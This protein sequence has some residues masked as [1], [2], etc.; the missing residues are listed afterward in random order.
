MEVRQY[1]ADSASLV[2]TLCQ[3]FGRLCRGLAGLNPRF[4]IVLFAKTSPGKFYIPMIRRFAIAG[5]CFHK[6][7]LGDFQRSICFELSVA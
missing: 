3:S 6:K 2:L 1:G 7:D 4:T 5:N